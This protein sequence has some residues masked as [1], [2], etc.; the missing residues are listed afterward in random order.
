MMKGRKRRRRR[1]LAEASSEKTKR[2]NKKKY[3]KKGKGRQCS[4]QGEKEKD[5]RTGGG[6]SFE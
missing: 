3:V 5:H 6:W 2:A 1:R 4:V